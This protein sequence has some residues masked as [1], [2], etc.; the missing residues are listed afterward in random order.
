MAIR[1][2]L[3]T[4]VVDVTGADLAS[5]ITIATGTIASAVVFPVGHSIQTVQYFQPAQ[6]SQVLNV[7]ASTS[8]NYTV[9]T[10]GSGNDFKMS[11]TTK[12]AN[13]KILVQP[14]FGVIV[15]N[16]TGG[17][18][19]LSARLLRDITG[20]TSNV[21][22]AE[23]TGSRTPKGTF[24]LHAAN[25]SYA[26][27]VGFQYLDSPSQVANK[28]ITY[29]VAL[30]PHGVDG[31][32]TILVNYHGGSSGSG[33]QGSEGNSVATFILQEIAV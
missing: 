11:I 15:P 16:N 25:M 20:G 1:R 18:Q 17:A 27:A 3:D 14:Y 33:N 29:K 9:L 10:D 6:F 4:N 32:Y 28:V 7:S 30:C 24:S 21:S 22:I 23:S 26:P 13:S 31:N 12:Q 2:P 5:D 19:G 8:G